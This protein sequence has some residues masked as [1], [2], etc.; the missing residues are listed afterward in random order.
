MGSKNF[1]TICFYV[2]TPETKNG[3][4]KDWAFASGGI[5]LSLE[6]INVIPAS[7]SSHAFSP[8]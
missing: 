4:Y 3:S 1:Q 6:F 2:I 7:Y 8:F 5:V